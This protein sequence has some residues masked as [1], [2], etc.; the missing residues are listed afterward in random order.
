MKYDHIVKINGQYYAA[1]QEIPD[2]KK[3]KGEANE[4]PF[5]DSDITLE[6]EP[7]RRGRPKK[8]AN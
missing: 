1:G 7:V 5:S 6:T 8:N 2:A 4:L 3:V